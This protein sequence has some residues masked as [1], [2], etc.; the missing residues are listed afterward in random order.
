MKLKKL[1][2]DLYNRQVFLSK[3]LKINVIRNLLFKYIFYLS[4]LK[5]LILKKL[6]VDVF[7]TRFK[8]CCIFTGHSRKISIIFK[9]SK[10]Q[11]KKLSN[12]GFIFGL[13]KSN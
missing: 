5:Y 12:L 8:N 2:K 7:I 3:E 10:F 4:N 13:K 11:I 6:K 9:M 1:K